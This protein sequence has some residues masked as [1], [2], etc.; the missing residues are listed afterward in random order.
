MPRRIPEHWTGYDSPERGNNGCP[1]PGIAAGYLLIII[2]QASLVVYCI[3]RLMQRSP[4]AITDRSRGETIRVMEI[5]TDNEAEERIAALERKMRDMDALV[6]GLTAELLDLKTVSMAMSRQD[7][8]R[9]RQDLKQGTVVRSTISPPLAAPSA[10]QPVAVP[11]E[12]STAIPAGSVS[13]TDAPVTP[14]EP[15]MVRMKLEARYGK[16]RMI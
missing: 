7:A 16:K 1:D 14:A 5:S 3:H 13:R 15:A 4:C 2:C 11:S 9:S 6:R 10:S 12:D 8:E